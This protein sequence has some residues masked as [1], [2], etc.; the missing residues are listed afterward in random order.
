[1]M[2]LFVRRALLAGT[3]AFVL[4]AGALSPAFAQASGD[5]ATIAAPDQ[6]I[7]A[8]DEA[9]E[10]I[11]VTGSRIQRPDYTSP[12]PIVSV[13]GDAITQTG[14]STLD[15]VI[16]QLPQ[17]TPSRGATSGG[18]AQG[19]SGQGQVTAN[20]RG[21][22]PQRTLVLLDG[23]RL[24]PSN[25]DGTIDL[26]TVPEALIGSIEAITGGASATYGSDAVSGVLNFKLRRDLEGLQLDAKGGIS[27]RGD[28]G[29]VDLTASWG[30]KFADDRGRAMFSLGFHDRERVQ[31]ISRDFYRQV[32]GNFIPPTAYYANDAGNP[33]D[34][35]ALAA[36][37]AAYGTPLANPTQIGTVAGL[38]GVNEGGTLYSI[39]NLGA[40]GSPYGFANYGGQIGL[41]TAFNRSNL[42]N[43]NYSRSRTLQ[44]ALR[45]HKAFGRVEYD[46]GSDITAYG[47]F[48]YAENNVRSGLDPVFTGQ[49]FGVF[50]PF[51][52]AAEKA[53]VQAQAPDLY[54]LLITRPNA[55]QAFSIYKGF[56][57]NTIGQRESR[58][59]YVVRQFLAGLQGKVGGTDLTW[60]VYGSSSETRATD[61]IEGASLSAI[62][63]LLADPAQC[64]GYNIFSA[65]AQ[66]A[67]CI[68]FIRRTATN[69]TTIR[70]DVVEATMQGSLFQLPA[71]NLRFAAGAGYRRN[72]YDFRPDALFQRSQ[73]TSPQGPRNPPT[74]D[75]VGNLGSPAASGTTTVTE[76]FGELLVPLI[77][78]TPFI[79]ELNLGL[80][81]RYSDYDT[82]GAIWTYKADLDWR[83]GGG[84][85]LRGGYNRA[86]RAP[87]VGE[88]YRAESGGFTGIGDPRNGQGDP[89]SLS[90]RYRTGADAAQV[91]ALCLATGMPLGA[92]DTYN[93]NY[94]IAVS[95]SLPNATLREETADT[96]SV[97][98]V[99][100]SRSTSPLLSKLSLSVDYYS[101]RIKDAVGTVPG[102]VSLAK[103]F[104]AGGDN[105]GFDPDNFYCSLILRDPGTGVPI[106]ISIP[107]LNL[108]TYKTS[109][110]DVQFDWSW[111]LDA[112][113]LG[114]NAG[115][116]RLNAVVNYLEQFRIQ[117]LP[118]AASLDYAGTIGDGQIDPF[119]ISKPRWKGTLTAQY[120][121][122]PFDLSVRWRYVDKMRDASRLSGSTAPG[123]KSVNYTDLN[124]GWRIGDNYRL[125]LGVDN[126]FDRSIP[127]WTGFGATDPVTYDVLGRRFYA[128]VRA[129]F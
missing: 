52:S 37:F 31:A 85:R 11:V 27:E 105:P 55:D 118:G 66:P 91:R 29:S 108:A 49:T 113:G 114:A 79:E 70:Q 106:Q 92:V 121:N 62:Q 100:T 84:F 72:S 57:D 4:M 42:L 82:V 20:I 117:S 109:G 50:V 119:G 36:R 46:L 34:P 15:S 3:P 7:D 2:K 68:D 44:A 102:N 54:S 10:A 58:S 98:G 43:I 99:W 129:G 24:A 26:S 93:Y 23:R 128:S 73:T 67:D 22:G 122:G 6:S 120:G 35:A 32:N 40:F 90:G 103:C 71:G 59:E 19:S 69:R 28:A 9:P 64:S 41:D 94:P 17:F 96:F 51:A 53:R 126:L 77:H 115:R 97:G 56:T 45:R 38:I 124:F 8:T 48:L 107:T 83:I 12:S 80:G 123:V 88:L 25:P 116:L 16:T 61:E 110:V 101:I 112:I 76:L 86:V 21:L 78:E 18:A 74:S 111:D 81:A 95:R 39:F 47:Q 104:N 13:G 75:F 5:D 1:M 65:A 63:S 30:A 60:E 14:G 87:S 125:S 127:T 89:C 33:F